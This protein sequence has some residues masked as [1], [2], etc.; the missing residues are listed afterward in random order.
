MLVYKHNSD[1]LPILRETV[2]GAFDGR[3][4]R[5]LVDDE[6]VLLRVWWVCDVLNTEFSGPGMVRAGER[7]EHTPTPARR[8]P[9][10][11]SCA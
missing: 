5:L 4:F 10:T 6:V 3:R 9:V 11:E 8:M 1:I 2:K 7:K